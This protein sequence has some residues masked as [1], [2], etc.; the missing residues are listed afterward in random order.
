MSHLASTYQAMVAESLLIPVELLKS[1]ELLNSGVK[2]FNGIAEID[3][4]HIIKGREQEGV[5]T[6]LDYDFGLIC[7]CHHV[8]WKAITKVGWMHP[9]FHL[10]TEDKLKSERRRDE[11]R[12]A[13]YTSID[14][15]I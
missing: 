14:T 2:L 13:S 4:M 9:Y 12:N 8:R 5:Q 11:K 6:K 3:L 7:W 15:I 1:L 10:F